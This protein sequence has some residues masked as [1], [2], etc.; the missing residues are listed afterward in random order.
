[1]VGSDCIV[2]IYVRGL[3]VEEREVYNAFRGPSRAKGVRRTNAAQAR[4]LHPSHNSLEAKPR[5]I[6]RADLKKWQDRIHSE[7]KC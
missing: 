2:E 6:S 1:M 3:N 7:E 4:R 5:K